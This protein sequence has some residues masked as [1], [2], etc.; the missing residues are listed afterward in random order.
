M[1]ETAKLIIGLLPLLIGPRFKAPGPPSWRRFAMPAADRAGCR[2]SMIPCFPSHR[3]CA[4]FS[5]RGV[6]A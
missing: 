3:G 4:L 2:P 6:Q 1:L 5:F